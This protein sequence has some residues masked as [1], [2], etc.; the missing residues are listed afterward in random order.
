MADAMII[1]YVLGGLIGTGLL[2]FGIIMLATG[3]RPWH[4]VHDVLAEMGVLGEREVMEVFDSCIV[5]DLTNCVVLDAP[6][7]VEAAKRMIDIGKTGDYFQAISDDYSPEPG[8]PRLTMMFFTCEFRCAASH[9][10]IRIMHHNRVWLSHWSYLQ[11]SADETNDFKLGDKKA[12]A[13][14]LAHQRAAK[15]AHAEGGP[16]AVAAQC[17]SKADKRHAGVLGHFFNLT[18]KVL[19]ATLGPANSAQLRLYLGPDQGPILLQ[20]VIDDVSGPGP[21]KIAV[22]RARNDSRAS[23]H[24]TCRPLPPPLS[25]AIFLLIAVDDP[26]PPM[27]DAYLD[28]LD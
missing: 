28:C 14:E 8:F 19:K 16:D 3:W 17:V 27:H 20:S 21:I 1:V 25:Q 10:T 22:F 23:S 24:L 26:Q 4:D 11:L 2:I 5:H 18:S 7:T 15:V 13:A 12:G 6:C 9:V